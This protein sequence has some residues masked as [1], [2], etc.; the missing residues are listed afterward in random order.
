MRGLARRMWASSGIRL[1]LGSARIVGVL[2]LSGAAERGAADAVAADHLLLLEHP[3]A[4]PELDVHAD[5]AR[6]QVGA[7]GGPRRL[8]AGL[9]PDQPGSSRPGRSTS[10]FEVPSRNANRLRA[11]LLWVGPRL[12]LWKPS[13]VQRTTRRPPPPAESRASCG[14]PC[15]GDWRRSGARCPAG[16]GGVDLVVVEGRHRRQVLRSLGGES[17]AAVEQ[18]RSEADRDRQR[19]RAVDRAE[20][21]RVR[22]RIVDLLDADRAA[23]RQ[24]PRLGR[25]RLQRLEQDAARWARCCRARSRSPRSGAGRESRI[26][27]VRRTAGAS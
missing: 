3:D 4:I 15:R 9:D 22:R 2:E 21:A 23:L 27:V 17:V 13:S 16:A 8:A 19:I 5:R 6:D 24:P 7:A 20:D 25:D 1:P 18:R 26:D 10:G 11:L 12:A 14:R